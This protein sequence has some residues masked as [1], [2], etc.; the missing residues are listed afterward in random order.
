MSFSINKKV[1]ISAL[2]SF[3]IALIFYFS[4]FLKICKSSIFLNSFSGIFLSLLVIFCVSSFWIFT[5]WNID[6]QQ[7]EP[8]NAILKTFV[9]TLLLHF[10][11]LF[12][13]QKAF[14]FSEEKASEVLALLKY[15]LIPIFTIFIV[16][17]FSVFQLSSFD[18]AVDSLI[19]GGFVGVGLGSAY[20][21]NEIFLFDTVSIQYLIQ[22]LVIRIFLCSSVCALTGLLFNKMRISSKLHHLVFSIIILFVVF[23]IYCILD[24]IIETNILVAQFD[25]LRFIVSF[26]LSF[27]I[28]VLTIILISK[29]INITFFETTKY[30]KSFFHIFGIL[31]FLMIIINGFYIQNQM[32]KTVRYFSPDKNW[33]FELPDTFTEE[34]QTS[35]FS[36]IFDKSESKNYQKYTNKNCIIY[37]SFNV[38]QRKLDLLSSSSEKILGWTIY[39]NPSAQ[40]DV[41]SSTIKKNDVL[42]MLQ[43]E[44]INQNNYLEN[45]QLVRNITKSLKEEV[46]K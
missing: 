16:F 27:I 10:F 23:S 28:F 4:S 25:N 38:D 39:E 30:G 32:N 15:V 46:K 2:Y 11:L 13:F 5:Y 3:L 17:D 6:T 22:S 1:V 40:S 41:L 29:K 31:I 33:S 9:I 34:K 18:E 43:I 42:I 19:Y 21:L 7:K 35:D 14:Q 26:I 36:T 37:I 20:I 12:L 44:Q 45:Y 8:I 24:N